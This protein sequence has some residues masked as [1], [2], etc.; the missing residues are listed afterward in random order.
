MSVLSDF[1]VKICTESDVDSVLGFFKKMHSENIYFLPKEKKD[2][3]NK[4]RKYKDN[5]KNLSLFLLKDKNG[6]IIGSSGYVP[7]KG[8]LCGQD[9]DGFVGSDAIIAKSARE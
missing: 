3:I 9:V 8:A 1:K 4:Y 2:I 5:S 7:F 6:N